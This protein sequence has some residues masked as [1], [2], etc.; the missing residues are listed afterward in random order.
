MNAIPL[1]QQNP[2]MNPS[3]SGVERLDNVKISRRADPGVFAS[4][5]AAIPQ[6]GQLTVRSAYFRP[7]E[8]LPPPPPTP[9]P[10]Q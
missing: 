9:Q 4:N 3:A 1:V 5:R 6:R 10:P 7:A 8:D 2:L